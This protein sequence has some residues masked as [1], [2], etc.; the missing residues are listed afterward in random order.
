MVA[1]LH[2]HLLPATGLITTNVMFHLANS[3]GYKTHEKDETYYDEEPG[4]T[5]KQFAGIVFSE[6]SKQQGACKDG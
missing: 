6:F 4:E 5:G 1:V 2:H 3:A